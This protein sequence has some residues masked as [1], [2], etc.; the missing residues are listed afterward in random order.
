V[1]LVPG[2]VT[3]NPDDVDISFE[4]E[5]YK[6]KIPVFASAMDGVVDV[7]FAIE[8]GKLGGLAVLNL[9]G[10]YTRYEDPHKAIERIARASK[11]ESTKVIQEVYKEP[12]KEELIHKRI[13]EIR[14]GGVLV[15]AS[16]IPQNAE[17]FGKIAQ[18]AGSDFFIVQSQ[19][20][21]VKHISS[22]YKCLDFEKL[23]KQMKIPVIFG[24]CVTYKACIQL[25]EVGAC[26]VFVGIGPGSACTTRQVLGIGVPQIT[27]TSDCAWA[28]DDYFKKTGRY[29]PVITDGGMKSGG[30][31]AKAFAA[32]ADA[33][34]LGSSFARAEESPGKGFHWGMA[35]SNENLPR[36]TKIEVSP[37]IP[38][39]KILFGPAD[40]DDGTQN[41]IGALKLSMGSVGARNIKEMQMVELVISHSFKIEGKSFQQSQKVGQFR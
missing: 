26:A 32:G 8:F 14:K 2:T 31:I 5:G 20:S 33:V 30:D 1:A 21:T 27:A 39:K 29:V 37:I 28:R 4:L 3:I 22:S 24:N 35:T 9:D 16:C 23:C 10:I 15:A 40:T 12:I 38:L 25:M 11:S 19:V 18:E 41:L 7:K 34:M 36:G 6:F 17:K 13:D